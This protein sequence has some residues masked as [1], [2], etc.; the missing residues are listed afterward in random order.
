MGQ[1]KTVKRPVTEVKL[2]GRVAFRSGT[3]GGRLS[4]M[5]QVVRK[6]RHCVVAAT[7]EYVVSSIIAAGVV[8]STYR[9]RRH[10]VYGRGSLLKGTESLRN[11]SLR[12]G[13]CE[14]P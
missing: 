12:N 14:S 6:R 4:E 11:M 1:A 3:V 13:S 10:T 9:L 8:V 2:D 7:I 5:P